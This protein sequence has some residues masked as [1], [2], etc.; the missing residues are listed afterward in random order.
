MEGGLFGR[1]FLFSGAELIL[2]YTSLSQAMIGHQQI[3]R[4]APFARHETFVLPARRGGDYAVRVL[5]NVF[6][7]C[8]KDPEFAIIGD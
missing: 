6:L 8:P 3:D 5:S 1:P 2:E 4:L 7:F